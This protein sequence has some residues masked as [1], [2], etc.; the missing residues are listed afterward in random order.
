MQA[1]LAKFAGLVLGV[2]SGFDRLSFRGTLRKLSRAA[3]LER[4]LW[5]NQILKKDFARHSQEV[6]QRLEEAS[7][8]QARE[9]GRPIQYLNSAGV[10]PEAEAR[11][12]AER[13]GIREGLICV[14][15]KV[16][17]CYSF[18]VHGNR[19]SK[20]LQVTYRQ[21][22]CLHLYHYQLHPVFG[23]MHARIQTWFPFRIDVCLNGHEWLARQMDRARLAY[24]RRDNCFTWLEDVARAQALFDEQLRTAWAG[25]LDELAAALNPTHDQIFARFPVRY[26]WSVPQSE[27]SSDVLFRSRA[28][29][30]AL[31]PRLVRHAIT[32]FGATDVLR[33]L[34]RKLT[35]AGGVPARFA[36]EVESDLKER[37][38]GVRLKHW[39]DGNTLKLYDKGTVLRPECTVYQPNAFKVYRAKEG[40]PDGP[41]AW[42]P[43]R[44]GVADLHRRA[45]VC[46]AANGRY[47]EAL[48][49]VPDTTPLSVWAEPLCRRVTEPRAA[50]RGPAVTD[51]APAPPAAASA[52]P[53]PAAQ[54]ADPTAA[55]GPQSA[56]DDPAGKPRPARRRRLRALNP[57]AREDS[58]LLEAVARPEF[59]INGL[60]NRD[61]RR[62]LYPTEPQDQAEDRRRSAAISRKLR[63]LRAHGL[64]R[65]VPKTH[66]Y[67]VSPHGRKAITALLA[68]R[69]A[70]ADFLTTNAA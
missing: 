46:G 12:I 42:R 44:L 6:T 66:R 49:A 64:I 51:V 61:I 68:A 1:F 57:L 17:P 52:A 8:R 41:K 40:D 28:D 36:G 23:F 32:T 50:A 56:G 30:L 31:Y 3:G 18:E 25:H 21:R 26:Y 13:D 4:Y 37:E 39:L 54:P 62:L 43:L 16:D 38:E 14:L 24:R 69:D 70:N 22:Q 67:I 33:F 45:E 60:R 9:M 35:A 65:K 47:L 48:A 10:S 20:R 7:L 29:L 2:L 55:T 59:L 19:A 63:L 58:D 34:G 53:G 15:R 5:D 27:W 11:R